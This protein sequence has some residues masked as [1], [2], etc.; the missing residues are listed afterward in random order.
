MRLDVFTLGHDT[1]IITPL[2][3]D[4]S[5]SRIVK[6]YSLFF[7]ISSTFSP[8]VL[9]DQ[10]C[11]SE[12]L[13]QSFPNVNTFDLGTQRHRV[14]PGPGAGNGDFQ[15][16]PPMTKRTFPALAPVKDPDECS[17]HS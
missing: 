3:A 1:S 6:C 10:V 14:I 5:T 7:I 15:T 9:V 17:K 13:D 8:L 12:Y 4:F 11:R 2:V 16:T